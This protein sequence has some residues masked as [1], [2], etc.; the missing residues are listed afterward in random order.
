MAKVP[1]AVEIL[2]KIWTA[3][4]GRTNVTDRQTTD[5]R[6]IAYS[7]REREFMIAKNPTEE[8]NRWQKNTM[9]SSKNAQYLYCYIICLLRTK[10]WPSIKCKWFRMNTAITDRLPFPK[11]AY[12]RDLPPLSGWRQNNI[13]WLFPLCGF[14]KMVKWSG[15]SRKS[16]SDTEDPQ[17]IKMTW[18]DD[19]ETADNRALWKSCV[20]QCAPRTC[21]RSNGNWLN[22]VHLKN[23]W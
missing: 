8:W 7:E 1:N 14:Q 10:S 17:N 21:G 5:G 15:R 4:V 16:C 12:N 18:T 6:A 22:W 20:A 9:S 3:W 23:G 11:H 2:R 19:G 13:Q